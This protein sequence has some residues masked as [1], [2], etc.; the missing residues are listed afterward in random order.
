MGG[1]G[2][3]G[4]YTDCSTQDSPSAKSHSA[5]DANTV[6]VQSPRAVLAFE[7]VGGEVFSVLGQRSDGCRPVPLGMITVLYLHFVGLFMCVILKILN[8]INK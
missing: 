4:W 8:S 6:E 3:R 7:E 2:Q 5:P 1:G